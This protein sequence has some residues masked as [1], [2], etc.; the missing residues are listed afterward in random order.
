MRI[1]LDTNIWR[2]IFFYKS[3]LASSLIKLLNINGAKILFPEVIELE[4]KELLLRDGLDYRSKMENANNN[5]S[6]LVGSEYALS[7]PS[8]DKIKDSINKRLESLKD[9]LERIPIKIDHVKSAINRIIKKEPPNSK[10]KEQ[11]RDSYIWEVGLDSAKGYSVLF[12]SE[13]GD[14]FSDKKLKIFHKSLLDEIQREGVRLKLFSSLAECLKDRMGLATIE[15]IDKIPGLIL[16]FIKKDLETVS[17]RQEFKILKLID[18]DLSGFEM[19]NT[20]HLALDFTITLGS[21]NLSSEERNIPKAEI[22]GTGDFIV[23]GNALSDIELEY[24][25]FIWNDRVGNSQTQTNYYVRPATGV[26]SVGRS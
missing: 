4:L 7:V 18:Y 22:K 19:D 26:Y 16:D 15:N 3:P 9:Y 13:D 5:L 1:L 2:K 11:F 25:K 17:N 23:E 10:N 14:F 24:I 20:N 6:S 12:V 21:E 8:D